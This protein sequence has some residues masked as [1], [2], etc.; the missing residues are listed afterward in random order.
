ML[1]PCA[2]K[3]ACAVLRGGNF[4]DK[5]TYLIRPYAALLF[6][7]I[8]CDRTNSRNK[9]VLYVIETPFWVYHIAGDNSVFHFTLN[10]RKWLNLIIN[11]RKLFKNGIK[12][13]YDYCCLR[14]VLSEFHLTN[15]NSWHGCVV[16]RMI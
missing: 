2:M 11:Q 4:S 12:C 7:V 8:A 13:V 1:E 5:T 15:K 6:L 3:V 10:Q 9:V 14:I 16:T